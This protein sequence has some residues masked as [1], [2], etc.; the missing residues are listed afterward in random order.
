M[1]TDLVGV[2][3]FERVTAW[4]DSLKRV[5]LLVIAR[6]EM[7]EAALTTSAGAHDRVRR[8]KIAPQV[9]AVVASKEFNRVPLVLLVFV[10]L[11]IYLVLQEP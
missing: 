6:I 1:L 10:F 11:L 8:A 2:K 9:N 4:L 7:S 3:N 5:G